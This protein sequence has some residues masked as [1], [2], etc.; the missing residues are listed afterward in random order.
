MTI[1]SIFLTSNSMLTELHKI[2]TR[3]GTKQISF[4]LAMLKKMK[5]ITKYNIKP[6]MPNSINTSIK[7]LC[8]ATNQLNDDFITYGKEDQPYPNN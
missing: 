4:F 1:Q 7:S 2:I 3:S 6:I 5:S 8:A